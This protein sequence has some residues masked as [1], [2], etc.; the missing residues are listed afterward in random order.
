MVVLFFFPDDVHKI[1]ARCLLADVTVVSVRRPWDVEV[2]VAITRVR[3]VT[4]SYFN[5]HWKT[6]RYLREL[7]KQHEQKL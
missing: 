7:Q 3:T 2:R 1:S 6:F 4:Q 5:P